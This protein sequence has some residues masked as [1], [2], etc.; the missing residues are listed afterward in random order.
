M[1]HKLEILP[2][3]GTAAHYGEMTVWAGPTASASLLR[4]LVDGTKNLRD[5]DLGGQIL[6]DALAG[7]LRGGDPEPA[8]PF[9][10]I[11]PSP[12]G[13][14]VLLH[15]P[16]QVWDGTRWLSP[17]RAP[18]WLQI[19]ATA[20][21][22]LL[23]LPVGYP[24]PATHPESPYNLEAGTVPGGGFVLYPE[25]RP[26]TPTR[27]AQTQPVNQSPANL[28][29][30]PRASTGGEPAPSPTTPSGP[31]PGPATDSPF[32]DRGAAIGPNRLSLAPP[33]ATPDTPTVAL[34][35]PVGAPPG[36][37]Q[38]TPDSSTQLL[39]T[40]PAGPATDAPT[41]ALPVTPPLAQPSVAATRPG[42]HPPR[43]R[44]DLRQVG[45]SAQPLPDSQSP[46]PPVAGQPVVPGVRCR[47]GHFNHP[48]SPVCHY[49]GTVLTDAN[50]TQVSGSR[51][52]LGVLI[53]DDGSTYVL[54][55]GYVIGT[56]PS[57]DPTVT[58]GLARALV[59]TPD[60]S[61]QISPVH[62]EIRLSGWDVT[63]TDRGSTSGTFVFPLGTAEWTRLPAY[64][65]TQLKPG[66]HVA[67]GQHVITFASPWS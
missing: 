33:T 14:A 21:S 62:A 19:Q 59:L 25:A 1:S 40:T 5:A 43:Q 28:G 2:G 7:V 23:V 22:A 61:G 13:W 29:P 39:P 31:P 12:A 26:S 36:P 9:V 53:V 37:D 48:A 4:Y 55:Q 49:C 6:S 51:P 16:V 46:A 67:C 11:G 42:G 41:Q 32:G 10:M 60:S 54:D 38:A 44:I 56:D 24:A 45:P 27:T 66:A 35:A 50:R 8:A 30:A 63:L 58:G 57:G 52:P 47:N 34:D 3:P 15:G 18:G 65:T 17:D 64:Q 20:P